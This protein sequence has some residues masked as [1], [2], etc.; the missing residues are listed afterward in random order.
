[1]RVPKNVGVEIEGVSKTLNQITE[2]RFS[3]SIIYHRTERL[4]LR[5]YAII[6][7][8]Y[9]DPMYLISNRYLL[10]ATNEDRTRL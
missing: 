5:L 4:S 8:D 6:D 1:M 7:A 9:D 2:T 3:P 10:S